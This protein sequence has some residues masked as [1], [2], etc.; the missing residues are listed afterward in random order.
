LY[1]TLKAEENSRHPLG[2]SRTLAPTPEAAHERAAE[3][4]SGMTLPAA[5]TPSYAILRCPGTTVTRSSRSRLLVLAGAKLRLRRGP[6]CIPSRRTD[7]VP[8]SAADL[9][10]AR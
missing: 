10:R 1:R 3:E 7:R 2:H 9:R 8:P 6:V 4:C 5:V